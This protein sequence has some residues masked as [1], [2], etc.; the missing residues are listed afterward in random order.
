MKP[1]AVWRCCGPDFTKCC[2][3]RQF[4]KQA[5]HLQERRA[6]PVHGLALAGYRKQSD[7]VFHEIT[8]YG[9]LILHCATQYWE[10]LML[11]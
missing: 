6:E 8:V 10:H 5:I 9:I 2:E 4:P 11:T 7:E 1:Y 3:Q